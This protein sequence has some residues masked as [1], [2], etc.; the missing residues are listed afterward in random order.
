[1]DSIEINNDGPEIVLNGPADNV[2]NDAI[3]LFNYTP[4]KQK[5]KYF[6]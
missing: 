6:I 5:K 1:M 4:G 3:L 2:K